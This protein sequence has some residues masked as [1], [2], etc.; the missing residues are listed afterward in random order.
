MKKKI[1]KSQETKQKNLDLKKKLEEIL[2]REELVKKEPKNLK[3]LRKKSN[4]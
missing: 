2:L 1:R 4:P 3:K